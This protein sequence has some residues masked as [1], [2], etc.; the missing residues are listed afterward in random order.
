MRSSHFKPVLVFVTVFGWGYSLIAGRHLLAQSIQSSTTLEQSQGGIAKGEAEVSKPSSENPQTLPGRSVSAE[1]NAADF[2]ERFVRPTIIGECIECHSSSEASG[3]LSLESVE[4]MLR[5]GDH[6]SALSIGDPDNSL[7]IQVISNEHKLKMPPEGSLKKHQID[8]LREWIKTGAVWPKH[9]KIMEVQALNDRSRV[10]DEK[11]WAFQPLQSVKPPVL[12]PES[13]E[14]CANA[15][16][17]FVMRKITENQLQFSPTADRRTLIRRVTY[18]LTGLPPSVS[19]V[20]EFLN[21]HSNDAWEKVVNRL[22]DSPRFGEKWAKH[23]L[24]IARYSDSKG[25]VYA[26]EERFWVHAWVYRDWVIGSLNRDLPYDEFLRLQ[27][28]ADHYA[29]DDNDLAAMGFLTLGRRF[30]GVPHDIIDDRID[31]LSRASMGLTIACARCH[32]HKYDPISIE[33]YYSLYGIFRN[34]EERLVPLPKGESDD[35]EFHAGL[36]QRQDKLN[37]AM[38]RHRQSASDR[39]RGR[40]KDYLL[41]QLHLDDYPEA[42]FDQIYQ[43]K[44]MIPEF[45]R[46]WRDFLDLQAGLHDRIFEPWRRFLLLPVD[47]FSELAEGVCEEIQQSA[48]DQIHPEVATRFVEPP[49]SISDVA[50]RYADLFASVSVEASERSA[51]SQRNQESDEIWKVLYG[52][53]G[54]CEI[55]LESITHIE[56]F[57]PTNQT[58]ELWKL[59][60]EI[61]RW[62]MKTP[63]APRYSLA[64]YDKQQPMIDS[65]LMRRGNPALLGQRVPRAFPASLRGFEP[66]NPAV[67]QFYTAGSGRVQL[68]DAITST[69]NPLT[70]RVAVNRIWAQYFGNGLVETLSDFGTR[71]APPSHP[72]LLDWLANEL[73]EGGWRQKRVHRLILLSNTYK[74]ASVLN[75]TDGRSRAFEIDPRNRLLWRFPSRRL[76]FE[77]MRDSILYVAGQCD[78]SIGGKPE[79]LFESDRRTIYSETDRQFFSSTMR[80]FDVASPDL[81]ISKRAETT[82]PQQ[83]LFFLNHPFVIAQSRELVNQLHAQDDDGRVREIYQ[84]VFARDPTPMEHTA[85]I[86]FIRHAIQLE[87]NA[88]QKQPSPWSYGMGHY[89]QAIERVQGFKLLPYFDGS[90]WQ[91]GVNYPDGQLGWVQITAEGGHPGNIVENASVRRWTAPDAMRVRI[92]SVFTHEPE[93]GDG[94]HVC[95]V[96]DRSGTLAEMNLLHD[97]VPI[98]ISELNVEEGE[99][100]DFVVDIGEVLNSDQYLWSPKIIKIDDAKAGN[101]RIWDARVD[102]EG[103]PFRELDP[104]VALTQVLLSSNEFTF[105]D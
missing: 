32:D 38:T 53:N 6:G 93:V 21:D 97:T 88:E 61:D 26:R 55:P 16:D 49:R 52:A 39:V 17:R 60:A 41:A 31:V 70:A 86:D 44:D 36:K 15:I 50:E 46:R 100:I 101:Q 2:F 7:L 56:R 91:G 78:L 10:G 51:D 62:I 13:D 96:S 28:A 67:S 1:A 79:K 30:L 25:Y 103:L 95:I 47:Q 105:V 98:E 81:S 42:G 57:F 69:K 72:E 54:P 48:V 5:G 35:A 59:Q 40:I 83:A 22:L 87:R 76:N 104:W 20:N 34:S 89:N 102:F 75:S 77:A 82:V 80:T 14:S 71:A 65:H 11:H 4:S 33:D 27:I 24:D 12:D 66:D 3:G 90:A 19:E 58:E 74:Q 45:V 73:I 9:G 94:V 64:L 23:W 85:V 18:D 99:T 92:E 29:T 68:A 37:D 63:R 84:R 8:T 43:E